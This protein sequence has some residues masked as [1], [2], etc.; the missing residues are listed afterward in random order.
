MAAIQA[1]ALAVPTSV[2]K[3]CAAAANDLVTFIPRCNPTIV[4]DALA[5][6]HLL[7]GAGRA[8]WRAILINQPTPEQHAEA[9]TVCAQL[10]AADQRAM[11]GS[12]T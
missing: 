10:D 2:L 12:V 4:S 11:H 9:T 5:A 1:K 3:A 8:A 6:I 7:A